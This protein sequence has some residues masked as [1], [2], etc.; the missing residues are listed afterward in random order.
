MTLQG[1]YNSY[2]IWLR[3]LC[4]SLTHD[5]NTSLSSNTR[6]FSGLWGNSASNSSRKGSSCSG[7]HDLHCELNSLHY[8]K[9]LFVEIVFLFTI[10]NRGNSLL[11]SVFVT[12]FLEDS[13]IFS[14]SLFV[15]S[16]WGTEK[17]SKQ[18]LFLFNMTYYYSRDSHL[19]AL[20]TLVLSYSALKMA[21]DAEFLSFR[22]LI[23]LRYVGFSDDYTVIS[24]V[25]G[26]LFAETSCSQLFELKSPNI[27]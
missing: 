3:F 11:F 6:D 23:W 5:L 12:F 2:Q 22:C 25:L 10:L 1:Y 27:W 18:C 4:Y 8:W 26:I 14:F 15:C 20:G 7:S 13:F 19:C 24:H 9:Y 17:N 16:V 21:T